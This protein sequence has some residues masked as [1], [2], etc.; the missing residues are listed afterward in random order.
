MVLIDKG[1]KVLHTTIED[2]LLAEGFITFKVT[3]KSMEPMLRNNLDLVTIVKKESCMRCQE[4][5]V[6]LYKKGRKLIL[7]RIIRV[8]PNDLYD[9]MGDNCST[10]DKDVKGTDVI[11]VMNDFKRNGVIYNIYN[12]QYQDYV[13]RLRSCEKIRSRRKFIYD[14]VSKA[15][16]FL[17]NVLLF[18]TKA[19]LKKIIVKIIEF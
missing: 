11:G 2:L 14:I 4:N 16:T 10:I 7:H 15:I 1:M 5:D 9:I 13:T 17:P 3:G 18:P 12:S 8:K 19:F 6:V